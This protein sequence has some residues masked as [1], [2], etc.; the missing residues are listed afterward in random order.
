MKSFVQEMQIVFQPTHPSRGATDLINVLSIFLKFQPTHPSRGATGDFKSLSTFSSNF[1]PRTPHG[2][3]LDR[4]D[5]TSANGNFNPRTPHGVRRQKLPLSTAIFAFEEP[6]GRFRSPFGE[7]NR[8]RTK[9]H[10]LCS[11]SGARRPGI[12]GPLPLRTLQTL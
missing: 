5:I 12:S 1:N 8:N 11:L 10:F 9:I 4:L 6:R 2:V 7:S 3:R